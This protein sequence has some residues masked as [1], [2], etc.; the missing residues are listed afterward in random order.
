MVRP[1]TLASW[2]RP[3][4][5]WTKYYTDFEMG[6]YFRPTLVIT[7]I[8]EAGPPGQIKFTTH[9]MGQHKLA[10]IL[11][12]NIPRYLLFLDTLSTFNRVASYCGTIPAL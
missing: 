8:T 11:V 7:Q 2:A 6:S 9:R 4:Q 12:E 3:E 10:E 5:E 1:T